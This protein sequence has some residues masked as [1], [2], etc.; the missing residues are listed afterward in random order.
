MVRDK[1]RKLKSKRSDAVNVTTSLP[2]KFRE[3]DYRGSTDYIINELLYL[4][5]GKGLIR[6]E[7]N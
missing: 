2:K 3:I 4:K 1:K 6:H 7:G 5:Y